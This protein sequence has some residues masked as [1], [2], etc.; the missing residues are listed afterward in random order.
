VFANERSDQDAL[1][2][3]LVERHGNSLV[4]YDEKHT[5]RGRDGPSRT[6]ACAAIPGRSPGR[7][8]GELDRAGSC[9]V[10]A[11]SGRGRFRHGIRPNPQ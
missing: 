3:F 10:R 8:R 7:A 11:R 9:R 6:S 4:A 5:E 2:E 1:A